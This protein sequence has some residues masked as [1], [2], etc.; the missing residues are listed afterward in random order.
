MPVAAFNDRKRKIK[1]QRNGITLDLGMTLAAIFVF[2]IFCASSAR[3]MIAARPQA[4]PQEAS[5]NKPAEAG[6]QDQ[7]TKSP[8][9]NPPAPSQASPSAATP[10]ATPAKT[11]VSQA[12]PATAKRPRRKKKVVPPNCDSTPSAAGQAAS[13]TGTAGDPPAPGAT[14]TAPTTSSPANCPPAKVIVRQGGTSEPSIQLAGGTTTGS[15]SHQSDTANQMLGSAEANLKK[16]AGRQLTPNQQDM[17]NQ[18]RQFMGQSKTSSEAGD[19]ERARTLAWKA[20]LLSE[21][22]VKPEK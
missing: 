8:A 7:G 10:A 18:I 11:P 1:L 17:V 16:I 15:P 9:Q 19:L 13:S 12:S 4:A 14:S 2:S 3:P 6:T 20:K 21:E 5:A 22:L